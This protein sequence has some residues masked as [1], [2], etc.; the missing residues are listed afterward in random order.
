VP[1]SKLDALTI[2]E[3]YGQSVVIRWGDA[4]E[5]GAP[6]FDFHHQTAAAQAKQ[7]GYNNDFVGLIPQDPQ[8]IRNLLVVNH[9]YTTQVQL[10][11]ADRYDAANPT[12]EQVKIAWARTKPPT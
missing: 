4:V 9:E 12:E 3:G 6:E 11:P 8:G 10:F 7:L 2:P 1:P 5:A